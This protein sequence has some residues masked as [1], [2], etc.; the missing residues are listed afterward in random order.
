MNLL[1]FYYDLP[2]NDRSGSAGGIAPVP[3]LMVLDQVTGTYR[4]PHFS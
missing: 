1:D 2:R 4:T 3:E